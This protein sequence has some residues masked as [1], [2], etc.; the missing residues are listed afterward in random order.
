MK[1]YLDCYPCLLSQALY[2]ARI[3]ESDEKNIHKILKRVCILLPELPFDATPPELGKEVY[4]LISEIAGVK[5]PFKAIKERCTQQALDLYPELKKI[6]RDSDDPL[7]TAIR[8]S[9]A[10]NVIDFGTTRRFDIGKDLEDILNLE[11]AIED[12]EEFVQALDKAK[13]ILFIGD[14]AGETVFDRLLIE[15]LGKPV[16]YV[17]RERPIINDATIKDAVAAGIDGVAR[18]ISS[19]SDAPGNIL[20]LCSD[21]FLEIYRTAD[22][23]VSKGQ[24]NY[25]GLSEES[26]P[27]F[28]FLK[29]KCQVIARDIGVP[30]GSI[31]LMKA[32]NWF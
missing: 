14:N 13:E 15:E 19:G 7:K 31:V 6:I 28:F 30:Q 9:I 2:T 1:A 17:V 32:K 10:G 16:I 29:A 3:V 23:I 4:N 27:I 22:L 20:N 11:F 18:I 5:D 25:E 8:I 26:L 24:G 21:E 12:Y